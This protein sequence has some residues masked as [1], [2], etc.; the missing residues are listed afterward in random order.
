MFV[1]ISAMTV[2]CDGNTFLTLL[3]MYVWFQYGIVDLVM[4]TLL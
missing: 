1:L 3:Y 4:F 2:D